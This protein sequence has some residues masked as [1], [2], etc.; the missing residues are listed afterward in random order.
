MGRIDPAQDALLGD[1]EIRNGRLVGASESPTIWPVGA[2][3]NSSYWLLLPYEPPDEYDL[4]ALF[5]RAAGN[6]EV[7]LILSHAKAHFCFALDFG[8]AKH[9]IGFKDIDPAR[10]SL[11]HPST[12]SQPAGLNNGQRY[13]VVV[14]VRRDGLTAELDGRTILHYPTGYQAMRYEKLFNAWESP[15]NRLGVG[16]TNGQVSFDKIEV[17][18]VGKPGI[19]PKRIPDDPNRV[20]RFHARASIRQLRF[21]PDG[22]RNPASYGVPAFE[23]VIKIWDLKTGQARAYP[24]ATGW[25]IL[26][27]GKFMLWVS[28]GFHVQDVQSGMEVGNVAAGSSPVSNAVVSPD[29]R[30]IAE[31][32]RLADHSRLVVWDVASGN[33]NRQLGLRRRKRSRHHG[34]VFFVRLQIAG[35][36]H[37]GRHRSSVER[38]Q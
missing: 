37:A 5:T 15:P 16:A 2:Y 31:H 17:S 35:R 10:E 28:N 11:L 29:G 30:L 18:E 33:Q 23:H 9:L 22:R 7:E 27:D 25:P 6:G 32:Q 38:R 1:W 13:A 20:A 19:L 26:Q 21:M 12:V 14:H 36:Q 34:Y 3:P 24:S 4:R 8:G